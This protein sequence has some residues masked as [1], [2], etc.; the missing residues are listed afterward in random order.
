MISLV[1]LRRKKD[2]ATVTPTATIENG[3]MIGL[4][5]AKR[6]LAKCRTTAIVK[7]CEI[8]FLAIPYADIEVLA[9]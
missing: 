9:G 5:N 2:R 7:N 8:L 3:L 6:L 4:D 1:L